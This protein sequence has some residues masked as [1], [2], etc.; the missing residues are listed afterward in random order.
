ML[1]RLSRLLCDVAPDLLSVE[2]AAVAALESLTLKLNER[3]F[4]PLFLRF[5]EWA[6]A[7]PALQTIGL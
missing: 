4:K 1:S 3:I 7:A 6:R 2:T 5:V